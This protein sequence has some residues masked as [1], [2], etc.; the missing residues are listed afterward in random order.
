MAATR[1][2]FLHSYGQGAGSC[3]HGTTTAI[4]TLLHSLQTHPLQYT[5]KN[6]NT[7]AHHYSAKEQTPVLQQPVKFVSDP[8][9]SEHYGYQQCYLI[10]MTL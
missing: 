3:T 7:L 8:G 4:D 1:E 9:Q 2:A 6:T 10:L 5:Q